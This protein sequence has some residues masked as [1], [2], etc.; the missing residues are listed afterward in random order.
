M[1]QNEPE[2]VVDPLDAAFEE[3]RAA[4]EKRR[5]TSPKG[6]AEKSPEVTPLVR[7]AQGATA[8]PDDCLKLVDVALESAPASPAMW[9]YSTIWSVVCSAL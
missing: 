1:I 5:Q 6:L 3:R 4:F 9:P 8:S 7:R 2:S